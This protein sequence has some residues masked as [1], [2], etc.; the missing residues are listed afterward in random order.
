MERKVYRAGVTVELTTKE[1]ALLEYLMQGRGRVCS[2]S[3]LLREVWQMSPDAG[4][5]VVDVYVNYLSARSWAGV[6]RLQTVRGEGYAMGLAGAKKP[7]QS[8]IV[9]SP[10]QAPAMWGVA[11]A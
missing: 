7:A 3:E 5:N 6:R 4:T 11:R 1:F 10:M 8:A 2:R 9:V